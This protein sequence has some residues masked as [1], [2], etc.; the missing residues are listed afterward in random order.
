[1][2]NLLSYVLSLAVKPPLWTLT[3]KATSEILLSKQNITNVDIGS[4]NTAICTYT[5]K[6]MY[7]LYNVRLPAVETVTVLELVIFEQPG[8]DN[9]AKLTKQ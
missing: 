2:S 8:S 1:M 4:G 6:E 5:R 3:N 9:Q 7:Q